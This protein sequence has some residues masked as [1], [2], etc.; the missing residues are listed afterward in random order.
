LITGAAP[1]ADSATIGEAF[2]DQRVAGFA[3]ADHRV[4]GDAAGIDVPGRSP[5][6]RRRRGSLPPDDRAVDA[7]RQDKLLFVGLRRRRRR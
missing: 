5:G 6:R 2:E 4:I 3:D 7:D 1:E